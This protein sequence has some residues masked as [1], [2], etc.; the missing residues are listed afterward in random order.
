M[1]LTSSFSEPFERI[2]IDLVSYSD[3]TGDCNKYI[4]TLQDDL[5][6]FV[7]AYPIPDK[8]A[9]TI[10]KSLLIFCQHYGIPKRFHSDQGGEFVNNILKQLMK[11]IGSNHTLSTAYHPQTNG[12]LERFQA[13]LRDHIRMYLLHKERP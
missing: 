4:L 8:Q 3:I 2:T 11:L 5:T 13:V 9:T 12:A 1:V 10:A 6:R 7:Q